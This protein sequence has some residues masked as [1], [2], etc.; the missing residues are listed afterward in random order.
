MNRKV[1]KMKLAWLI[2]LKFLK[3]TNADDETYTSP[4]FVADQDKESAK[5]FSPG[6]CADWPTQ[7]KDMKQCCL[8]FWSD[9]ATITRACYTNCSSQSFETDY[10]CFL[11]CYVSKMGLIKNGKFVKFA[12]SNLN[13]ETVSDE[14]LDFAYEKCEFDASVTMTENLRQFASCLHDHVAANCFSYSNREKCWEVKDRVEKCRGI[15]PQCVSFPKGLE[16]S[17][18]CCLAPSL[19]SDEKSATCTADCLEKEFFTFR[20]E[21]CKRNCTFLETGVVTGEG[22][23][24]F[25]KVKSI[26]LQNANSSEKW[27]KPIDET[28]EKCQKNFDGKFKQRNKASLNFNF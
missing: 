12:A 20:I 9:D 3:V 27:K 10:E 17:E 4:S 13:G 28:V 19:V 15:K 8:L 25:T 5:L 14:I 6:D 24:D 1:F 16:R 18:K 2:L 11:E 26:L 21:E 7:K 23:I 22:T